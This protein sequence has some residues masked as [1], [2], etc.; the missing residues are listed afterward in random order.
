MRRLDR[1]I[2]ALTPCYVSAQFVYHHAQHH[3]SECGSHG[4]HYLANPISI[5]PDHKCSRTNDVEEAMW[6]GRIFHFW[7]KSR[8]KAERQSD[9]RR[10]VEIRL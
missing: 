5:R 8:I 2:V 3:G 10:L 9:L 4:T 1:Y 7:K 6:L